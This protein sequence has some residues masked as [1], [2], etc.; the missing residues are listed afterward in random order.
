MKTLTLLAA[1]RES[2]PP[3][4]AAPPC[5]THR[6]SRTGDTRVRHPRLRRARIW[7]GSGPT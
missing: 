7:A 5:S 4:S 2:A 6:R 3:A 1:L